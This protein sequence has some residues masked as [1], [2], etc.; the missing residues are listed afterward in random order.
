VDSP[1]GFWPDPDLDLTFENVRIRNA[2]CH[3][4]DAVIKK[5]MII[6][7]NKSLNWSTV[8]LFLRSICCFEWMILLPEPM[9][10]GALQ[11]LP[12]DAPVV[13]RPLFHVHLNRI[14][15][16]FV[17]YADDFGA[18]NVPRICSITKHASEKII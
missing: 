10:G 9:Y 6:L 18:V 7:K 2:G 13:L 3:K 17:N 4:V 14:L 1:R 11:V 15:C 5:G 8:R 16:A 12:H